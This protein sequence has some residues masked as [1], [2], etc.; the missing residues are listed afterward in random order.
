MK[1]KAITC[2]IF[3]RASNCPPFGVL[4]QLHTSS[5]RLCCSWANKI[6]IPNIALKDYH[7]LY[8]H[9]GKKLFDNDDKQVE[10]VT[11]ILMF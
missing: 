10:T 9:I 3:L 6:L 2:A 4:L 1:V 11:Y 7:Y 8:L 5:K